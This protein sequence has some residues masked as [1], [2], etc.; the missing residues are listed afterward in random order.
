MRFTYT[1]AYRSG[2]VCERCL[3]QMKRAKRSGSGRNFAKRTASLKFRAPQQD[4]TGYPFDKQLNS[5]FYSKWSLTYTQ[6]YRSGHNGADSKGSRVH[7]SATWESSWILR[8]SRKCF[9]FLEF[10]M[11]AFQLR[12]C[13]SRAK[14]KQLNIRRDIEVVIT[15]LTRKLYVKLEVYLWK[16]P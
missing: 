15:G 9:I 5:K 16:I 2:D 4:I 7:H 3:W 14:F 6:R 8:L 11:T 13:K 12:P 10:W 1:E